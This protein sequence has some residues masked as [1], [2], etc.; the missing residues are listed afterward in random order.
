MPQRQ[1]AMVDN[2]NHRDTSE[3]L[4]MS[5]QQMLIRKRKINN[6]SENSEDCLLD[7]QSMKTASMVY[8][9]WD[10][11]NSIENKTQVQHQQLNVCE[12]ESTESESEMHA[13]T[14]DLHQMENEQDQAEDVSLLELIPTK[15]TRHDLGAEYHMVMEKTT[16]HLLSCQM[17]DKLKNRVDP[18]HVFQHATNDNKFSAIESEL[19]DCPK[20]S[21][22]DESE[23]EIKEFTEDDHERVEKGLA[24][25]SSDLS[26]S[27]NEG[28]SES[29]EGG[30]PTDISKRSEK[31]VVHCFHEIENL[32][33]T[34]AHDDIQK[35]SSMDPQD[36][37]T[38]KNEEL[39]VEA[40]SGKYDAENDYEHVCV[41]YQL[42]NDSLE[43]EKDN[44]RVSDF[45]ESSDFGNVQSIAKMET[46]SEKY[47]NEQPDYDSDIS[48][49][50]D[51]NKSQGEEGDPISHIRKEVKN[52]DLPERK[53]S[54]TKD[55]TRDW[56]SIECDEVDIEDTDH[57]SPGICD[58][59]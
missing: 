24:D 7:E 31:Q 19:H 9:S 55:F 16:S 14:S 22:E 49:H 25:Y 59:Q 15:G 13:E 42:F 23:D 34:S 1:T 26:E 12:E 3:P 33:T 39:D 48:S 50:G 46:Y 11:N 18:E 44:R 47:I 32:A 53:H 8:E 28:N 35:E 29:H 51:Y 17:L 54:F 36:M 45:G 21:T 6:C 2:H 5:A 27:E 56:K 38:L 57:R 40:I 58:C 52:I 4:T 41:N 30:I 43:T 20:V 10:D 37:A